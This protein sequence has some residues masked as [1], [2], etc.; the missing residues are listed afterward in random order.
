[1]T[2]WTWREIQEEVQYDHFLYLGSP[3]RW[4]SCQMLMLS[5]SRM[6]VNCFLVLLHMSQLHF[7]LQ[8]SCHRNNSSLLKVSCQIQVFS[9]FSS[10]HWFHGRYWFNWYITK[11]LPKSILITLRSK[12]ILFFFNSW[13][14]TFL[15]SLSYFF[16]SA[17]LL[18]SFERR[19]ERRVNCCCCFSSSFFL[20]F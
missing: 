3:Q 18:L 9:Y 16:F 8:M 7:R 2:R 10:W 17:F 1:M 4:W 20:K 11:T 5:W 6:L 13:L 19:G 12:V 14:Q 15:S